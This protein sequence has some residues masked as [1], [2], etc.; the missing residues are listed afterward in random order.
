MDVELDDHLGVSNQKPKL[1]LTY[2]DLM[3]Q[4]P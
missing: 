1:T 4:K 3:V 2:N